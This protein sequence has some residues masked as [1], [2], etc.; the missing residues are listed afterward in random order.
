MDVLENHISH[1]SEQIVCDFPRM[2]EM[3]LCDVD[4]MDMWFYCMALMSIGYNSGKC[5]HIVGVGCRM[6]VVHLLGFVDHFIYVCLQ[7]AKGQMVDCTDHVYA[8]PDGIYC[9]VSLLAHILVIVF[10]SS[11]D[12]DN[13]QP[14]RPKGIHS[15]LPKL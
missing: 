12:D 6:M 10:G 8:P 5:C 9:N 3:C 14:E 4:R 7:A 2:V 1:T 13:I 15:I 11:S